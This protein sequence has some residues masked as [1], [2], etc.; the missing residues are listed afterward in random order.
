L[1][2]FHSH[3][4]YGVEVYGSVSASHLD[5]LIKLNRKILQI[6]QYKDS[7]SH[8]SELFKTFG[9]LPVSDLYVLH[10]VTVVHEV[11]HHSYKVP[12]VLNNYFVLHDYN[13][14]HEDNIHG[15]AIKTT[16]GLRMIRYKGP[17]VW[18]NLPEA[19][20]SV[21]TF[22]KNQETLELLKLYSV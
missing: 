6:L 2:F 1:R 12:T 4:L 18:N 21:R 7:R 13:T 5:I 20:C 8:V 17:A 19:A 14:R 3:I 9:T 10:I 15:Y 11:F 16:D 22:S